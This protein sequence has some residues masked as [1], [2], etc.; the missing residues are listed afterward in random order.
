LAI[1][2]AAQIVGHLAGIRVALGRP[3]RQATT[4]NVFEIMR[5]LGTQ[6]TR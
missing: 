1:E 4:A 3:M 5:D 6:P 2:E